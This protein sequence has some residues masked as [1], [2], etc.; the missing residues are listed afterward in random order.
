M[1]LPGFRDC[2]LSPTRWR[3]RTA[4]LNR[5][6]SKYYVENTSTLTREFTNES[7]TIRCEANGLY[8]KPPP[9][10]QIFAGGGQRI[11]RELLFSNTVDGSLVFRQ[12]YT[13]TSRILVIPVAGF[14][15]TWHRLERV[16]P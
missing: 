3:S 8:I 13:A 1:S 14:A 12:K 5:S 4:R 2:T 11:R 7:A 9:H 15:I 10:E 16:V 6:A